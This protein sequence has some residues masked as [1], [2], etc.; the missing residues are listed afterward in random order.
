MREII[1]GWLTAAIGL[2]ILVVIFFYG[3]EFGTWVDEAGSLR[4][5]PPTF[6]LPFVVAGLGLVLFV[7][8]FSVGASAGVQRSKSRR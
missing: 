2:A 4:S 7:G 8:G 6:I 5:A 1:W 3:I